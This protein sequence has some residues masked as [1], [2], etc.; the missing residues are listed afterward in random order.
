MAVLTLCH[1]S[2]LIHSQLGGEGGD[3]IHSPSITVLPL[4][5]TK[6]AKLTFKKMDK[7]D[8]IMTAYVFSIGYI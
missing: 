3:G 7:I 8:V 6:T 1:L 5:Q 4:I 2:D